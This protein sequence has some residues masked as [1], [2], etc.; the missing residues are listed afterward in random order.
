[1]EG[2]IDM[3]CQV[4]L[5]QLS[6]TDARVDLAIR[7]TSSHLMKSEQFAWGIIA[8]IAID[9]GALINLER[10]SCTTCVLHLFRPPIQTMLW[11]SSTIET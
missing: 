10:R 3:R 4:P 5:L 2:L 7:D 11:S 1:M 9:S 8:M 6:A